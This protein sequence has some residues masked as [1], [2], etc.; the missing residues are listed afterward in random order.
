MQ[1]TASLGPSGRHLTWISFSAKGDLLVRASLS[2]SA[3]R[4]LVDFS[5]LIV[6]FD[7]LPFSLL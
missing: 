1:F 2:V 3:L 7:Q 4:L 6:K 5:E